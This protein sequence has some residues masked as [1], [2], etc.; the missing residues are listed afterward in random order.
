MSHSDKTL[1]IAIVGAGFSGIMTAYHLIKD[2]SSPISIH[3]IN[4]PHTFGRGAAY[5]TQ[6]LKHLL[7]VP[8]AKMSALHDDPNH[9][10]NWIHQLP[11]YNAVNKDTLG[12]TFLPRKLYGDYFNSLWKEALENKR[13][14]TQVEFIHDVATDIDKKD[15][16]YQI[17]LQSTAPISAD[18]VVLATGN[19]TPSNPSIPNEAFFQSKSYVQNPWLTDVTARVKAGQNILI[20]GNGLTMVDLIISIMSTGYKG[21]IHTLSPSGFAVLPHRHNHLEYKDFVNELTEPYKLNDIYSKFRKHHRLLYKV[22]LSVEPLVDSLRPLTHKIW[23]ALSLADKKTFIKDLRT[24]WGKVRHRLAPQLFD[25]IQ[26]LR[27]KND[28]IIH[29]GKLNDIKEGP[30]GI[31]INYQSKT[32][33][34]AETLSVGLV[35]N[36]TGPHIDIT[37]SEDPLLQALVAKGMIQ[38]DQL[39]IGMDVTDQWLLKDA[40]G[41]ENSGLYTLGGNLRGLLWETTAVPE[42][43]TQSAQLAKRILAAR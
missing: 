10:L 12:K 11:Q 27:L 40:Y 34:K 26:S 33:G 14:D 4:P 5:S 29:K 19:E 21:Q 6:T 3:I 35:V 38:P 28:L 1:E 20:L 39:R 7:N 32:T 13:A 30:D 17:Q 42:L 25:Y 22:G 43:K 37:K 36:C 9:F 31:S 16:R 2:A 41:N 24:P 18:T 23:G 15:G 8:A